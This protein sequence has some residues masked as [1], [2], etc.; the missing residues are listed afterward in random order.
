VSPS[1]GLRSHEES[2]I[3]AAAAAHTTPLFLTFEERLDEAAHALESAFPDPWIRSYSLKADPLPWII[4]LLSRRGWGANCVS[5]G[6]IAAARSAGVQNGSITLEGIGKGDEEFEAVI[7]AA[8]SGAPFRWIAVESLDEV[9][10]LTAAF[11]EH[12]AR[13]CETTGVLVRLNPSIEPGTHVGLAVG[14]GSSKFGADRTEL[15]AAAKAI[16]D[17]E[18]PL[19]LIGIHLHAGSQLQDLR[20]WQVAVERSL[21]AYDELLSL[22]LIRPEVHELRGTLCVGGGEPISLEPVGGILATPSAEDFQRAADLAWLSARGVTPPRRAI[23]PGRALVAE[24]TM[25]IARVLHV[26]RRHE[27]I[28]GPLALSGSGESACTQQVILDAGMGEL[29]RPALYGARHPIHPIQPDS[30]ASTPTA[31][32][33]P[34]C[35]STDAFGAHLLPIGIERGDLVAIAGAGAYADAMWSP[36]NSRPRPARLLSAGETIQVVRE[37]TSLTF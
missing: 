29:I 13:D 16:M 33:G 28:R 6:E 27:T 36:Y 25:L 21:A 7:S 10:A 31:V 2:S 18:V 37:R 12:R 26:R 4:E 14:R 35:E 30:N 5:V 8:T 3:I 24:A 34:I 32:H 9:H 19:Q 15:R 23:E 22:R 17:S 1:P 20:Q 11:K